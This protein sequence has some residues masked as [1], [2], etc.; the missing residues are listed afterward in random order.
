PLLVGTLT[1]ASAQRPEGPDVV[2]TWLREQVA[3]TGRIDRIE[4]ATTSE[5]TVETPDG[6]RRIA[7][8]ARMAG[9]PQPNT[10]TADVGAATVNGRPV[11]ARQLE[12]LE[13]RLDAFLP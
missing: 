4:V 7:V 6:Q 1:P 5:R 3:Q 13:R 11:T 10:W 9:H 12:M 8:E 2:Q